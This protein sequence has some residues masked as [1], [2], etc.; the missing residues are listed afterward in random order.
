MTVNENDDFTLEVTF[1]PEE[2]E[3]I[4]WFC[5]NQLLEQNDSCHISVKNGKS[6][7]KITNADKK[8]IGKYEV[9][10]RK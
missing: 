8:K 7:I 10:V 5:N 2:I 3:K 4:T 6:F 1:E 9:C